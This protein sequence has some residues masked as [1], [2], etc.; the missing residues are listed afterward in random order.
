MWLT[1]AVYFY[2]EA[3]SFLFLNV[4]LGLVYGLIAFAAMSFLII[5]ISYNYKDRFFSVW[6]LI[7]IIF[8]CFATYLAFTQPDAAKIEMVNGYYQV[9]WTGTFDIIGQLILSLF[10]FVFFGWVVVTLLYSPYILRKYSIYFFIGAF[11]TSMVS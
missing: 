11:I 10:A 4:F 8:G 7:I 9:V 1:F 5:A 3:V 6:L 2:L